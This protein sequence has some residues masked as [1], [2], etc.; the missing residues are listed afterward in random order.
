MI[1]D[2]LGRNLANWLAIPRKRLTPF[3]CLGGSKRFIAETFSG[4]GCTPSW[5]IMRPKN[6]I[7]VWANLHLSF[8]VTP[9]VCNFFK[10]NVY[11]RIMFIWIFSKDQHV[12]HMTN[13][14][15]DFSHNFIHSSLKM[16]WGRTNSKRQSVKT[17]T[18]NRSYKCG[19]IFRLLT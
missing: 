2:R 1:S 8:R 15:R 5:S 6:L 19:Q 12:I 10:N 16:F 11:S 3:T 17:K 9:A 4:S 18:S 14:T 13:H 7:L